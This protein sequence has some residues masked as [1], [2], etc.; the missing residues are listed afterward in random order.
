MGTTTNCNLSG[1]E[2]R[3]MNAKAE[4][5]DASLGTAED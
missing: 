2:T 1:K 4:A 5:P 3:K